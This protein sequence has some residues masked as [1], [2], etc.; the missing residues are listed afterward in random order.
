MCDSVWC[1]VGVGLDS[2]WSVSVVISQSVTCKSW[3]LFKLA[4]DSFWG[5]LVFSS[6]TEKRLRVVWDHFG[7]NLEQ[8]YQFGLNIVSFPI[9]VDP[10]CCTL[11]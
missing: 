6:L 3:C 7:T 9:C 1:S 5:G 2:V 10:S 11:C 8:S 4:F